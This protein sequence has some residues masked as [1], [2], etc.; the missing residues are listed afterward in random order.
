ML[1]PMLL[2]H[3][4]AVPAAPAA[5]RSVAA[6]PPVKVWFSSD[7]KYLFGDRAKVY[8]RTAEDSYLVVLR[9]DAGRV[10][11]LFPID[12]SGDQH[13]RGG[14]R[15]ELQG[16]GGREA[17]VV[18]DTSGHGTV[19]AAFSKTP[20]HVDQFAKDG[21][22]DYSALDQGVRDDAEARL[23]DIVQRM[24]GDGQHFD[25]DVATFAVAPQPRYLGW[26]YAPY[27]WAGWWDPWYGSR[28]TL[29]FGFRTPYYY[30]PFFGPGR[31]R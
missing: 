25:Y 19:L 23:L 20:F 8:A 11:V 16:R 5:A 10:R 30:R 1:L 7:G 18:D 17:F 21:R 22:W 29:G 14:K 15:S 24:H 4:L 13:L 9:A 2:L 12:P 28:I 27:P 31:W 3:S 26:A 6:D